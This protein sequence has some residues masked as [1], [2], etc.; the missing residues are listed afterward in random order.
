MCVLTPGTASAD[1]GSCS[2]GTSAADRSFA[3]NRIPIAA[4][5]AGASALRS[6]CAGVSG[7]PAVPIQRASLTAPLSAAHSHAMRAAS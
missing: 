6:T 3:G 7:R 1:Q 5:A 4:P 2:S